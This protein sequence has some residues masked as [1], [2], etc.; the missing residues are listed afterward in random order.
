MAISPSNASRCCS[1]YVRSVDVPF[2]EEFW[3][4]V[5]EDIANR[6]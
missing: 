2:V 4:R 6:S 5:L 3:G 1:K